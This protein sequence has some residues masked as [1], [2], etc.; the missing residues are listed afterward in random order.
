MT[1]VNADFVA[2][3]EPYRRELLAH[4]YRMLGSVQEAEDLVQETYL[5]AW[6]SFDRFEGRSSIRVWLYK[7]ATM[8]SLTA[9][10]NRS[11]RPLQSDL[12]EPT[13]DYR[14]ALA[15]SE[16]GALW[17]EPAPDSVFGRPWVDDPATIVASR[18]GIRLAF[19]AAL[20]HLP[21]R[22]R[23]VLIFRDVLGWRAAEVADVLETT[24]ASVNS[25]L[26]RARTQIEE[27]DVGEDTAIE[28]EDPR[29]RALLDRYVRAFESA[30][31]DSLVELLRADVEFE[32]PPIP[33]WLAGRDD[34]VGFLAYRV[35]RTA[36]YWRLVPVRANGQ[37]AVAL[38]ERGEDGTLV[39]HGIQVLDVKGSQ[40]AR[41]VSFNDESL[42][43]IF[44]LAP[45][46]P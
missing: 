24:T 35:L 4:C 14:T 45:T 5:R 1:V 10:E 12:S 38:Y 41:V 23:A 34:V 30:D 26:Q 15:A 25:A 36:G 19:I 16:P 7:I 13:A 28:P 17:L 20:Q 44:G 33:F 43:P 31:V 22:Q 6:R 3:A 42:V 11:R 32:M 27:A 2:Q 18:A 21:P 39:A 37:P 29:T 9:L 46:H 8:A 40:I